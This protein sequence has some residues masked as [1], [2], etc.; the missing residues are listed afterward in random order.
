MG[1]VA[2]V[3][4]PQMLVTGALLEYEPI[5]NLTCQALTVSASGGLRPQNTWLRRTPHFK[6]FINNLDNIYD[7]L[8]GE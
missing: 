2:E 4:F 6:R 1:Q 3:L 5:P 8:T 7:Y